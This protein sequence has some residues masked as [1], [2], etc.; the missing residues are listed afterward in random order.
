[1][2]LEN[3]FQS[4]SSLAILAHFPTAKNSK[5]IGTFKALW[6]IWSLGQQNHVKLL[7]KQE[8]LKD[9]WCKEEG[10]M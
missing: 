4:Y 1:M 7:V 6:F 3:S 2:Y 5:D 9:C 10:M 8:G